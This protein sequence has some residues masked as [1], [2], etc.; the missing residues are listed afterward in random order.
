MLHYA[1]TICGPYTLVQVIYTCVHVC[2]VC[3]I[4]GI[5]PRMIQV[6]AKNNTLP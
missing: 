4:I 3:M 2:I 6:L 5:P 1:K